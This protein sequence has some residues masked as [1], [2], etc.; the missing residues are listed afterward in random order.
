[1]LLLFMWNFGKEST[2][3]LLDCLQKVLVIPLYAFP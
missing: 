3:G 1:M 2:H